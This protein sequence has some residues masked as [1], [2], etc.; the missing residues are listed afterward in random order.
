MCRVPG[1]AGDRALVVD[2][3]NRDSAPAEASDYG[4]A[5]EV[6]SEDHR[7]GRRLAHSLIPRAFAAPVIVEPCLQAPIVLIYDAI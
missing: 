3:A 6:A 2:D 1:D 5:V 7:A 4:E